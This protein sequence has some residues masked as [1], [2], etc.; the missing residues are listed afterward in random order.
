MLSLLTFSDPPRFIGVNVVDGRTSNASQLTERRA[1]FRQ[2]VIERDGTCVMTGDLIH[3]C[4]ACHI[5]PHVKGDDV[6]S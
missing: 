1:D 3:N 5:I 2:R 4:N 6:C